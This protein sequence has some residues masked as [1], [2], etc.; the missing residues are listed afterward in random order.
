MFRNYLLISLRSLRKHRSYSI[1]NI[2]GLGLGLAA[3]LLLVTWIVHEMSYDKFHQQAARIYRS[4]M[5]YSFGGQTAKTAVSPTALLPT[6]EKNFAEVETGV[7]LYNPS[8]WNPFI[9]RR[10][11]T[12]F[13]EGKF[14]YA[15]STFFNIFSFPLIAGDATTALTQPNSVVL[16]RTT[17]KKYFG[18]EDPMGKTLQVNNDKEYI[19]TGVMEDVPSNSLLQFD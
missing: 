10:G 7:R 18:E 9:V 2:A 15:D 4:S 8:S 6:L 16:T 5:E 11:E 19:V 12:L 14:F 3:C 1:I 13:Q 17:A